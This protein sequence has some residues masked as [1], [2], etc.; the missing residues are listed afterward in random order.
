MSVLTA[1]RSAIARPVAPQASGPSASF[2]E[3]ATSVLRELQEALIGLLAAAPGETHRATD[4]ER[5]FGV[6]YKLA[7]QTF[8]IANADNPLA[9]GASVPARVSMRKLLQA[10]AKKRIPEQLIERVSTAFDAFEQF[11]STD[12]GDR[13]SLEAL[14]SAFLPEERQKQ[15]LA[16]KAADFKARS[17]INGIAAEAEL[18]TSFYVPSQDGE[19]VD[20]AFVQGHI[21]LRRIWPGA[22]IRFG[23]EN[24]GLA[25]LLTLD[26]S[27]MATGQEALLREFSTSPL[28]EFKRHA[29]D[30]ST[31]YSVTE[32]DIGLRSAI[33]LV[34][35]LLNRNNKPLHRQNDGRTHTGVLSILDVPSKRLTMDIFL[36]E[37]IYPGVSPEL[38]IHDT[39]RDGVV[40][41]INDP[42]REHDRLQI[43]EFVRP[44][45]AGFVQAKL[46]HV[47]RYVD[48]L[49]H[50]ADKLH[51][52]PATLRGYR[53][54][55]QYPVYATQYTVAF[56]MPEAP[57][58]SA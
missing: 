44:L 4:V 14:L 28:P 2:E 10:A 43:H 55:V 47:P 7:W 22:P 41:R 12:A 29:T 16:A 39:S 21:G 52:D 20:L 11:V 23:Y 33:D 51:V 54:D 1:R 13:E 42:S 48:M 15:E 35:G 40:L 53:L 50:A 57:Q 24:S 17:Q 34:R 36:H 18:F 19:M 46:P 3:V 38:T 58:P 9:A 25:K 27:P 32:Q 45:G 26:G 31:N 8:R 6:D 37:S 56:R 49:R 30:M 5:A